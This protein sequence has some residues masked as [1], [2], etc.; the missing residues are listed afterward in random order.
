MLLKND[1]KQGHSLAIKI[2]K[3]LVSTIKV[4]MMF[5]TFWLYNITT[6]SNLEIKFLNYAISFG[7][8]LI[9]YIIVQE[10]GLTQKVD[11]HFLIWQYMVY[12]SQLDSLIYIYTSIEIYIR[13]V[14]SN[15]LSV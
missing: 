9:W 4:K 15:N 10:I 1:V 6:N 8:C 12:F 7:V 13:C 14:Q 2:S 5:D 3:K 11:I